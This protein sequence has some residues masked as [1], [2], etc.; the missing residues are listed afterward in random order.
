MTGAGAVYWYAVYRK[1]RRSRSESRGPRS[2]SRLSS[3]VE[4][5]K[6]DK[7]EKEN[8]ILLKW[9][10][11]LTKIDKRLPLFDNIHLSFWDNSAGKRPFLRNLFTYSCQSHLASLCCISEIIK[12]VWITLVCLKDAWPLATVPGLHAQIV[13]NWPGQVVSFQWTTGPRPLVQSARSSES[14]PLIQ[15]L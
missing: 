9:V 8:Q 10:L 3:Q 4:R 5:E 14:F 1:G 11:F 7:I 2:S 12:I 6:R 15:S 13:H